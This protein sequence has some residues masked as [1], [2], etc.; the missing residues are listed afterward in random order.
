[1]GNCSSLFADDLAT[2]FFFKKTENISKKIN[3]YLQSLVRWL[4]KYPLKMNADKCCYNIFSGNGNKDQAFLELN[5]KNSLIPY[6]PKP[7]FLG[8]LFDEFLC[9]WELIADETTYISKKEQFTFV[10]RY[11]DAC[12]NIHE[13]FLEFWKTPDTRKY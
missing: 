11:A 7:T 6:N 9:F 12:L 8:I 3:L 13:R 10:V 1:L 5:L 4:Y 2:I